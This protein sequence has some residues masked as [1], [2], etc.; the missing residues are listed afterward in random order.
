V[1]FSEDGDD[2]KKSYCKNCLSYGFKVPLKN[3]I[4]P[5]NEPIPIDDDQF[6]QCYECGL[7]VPVYENEKESSIKDVV[8]TA[9]NPFDIGKS[10][11]GIDSRTS[12]GGKNARKKRDRQK[13]LE[14]IKDENLKAELAKGNTSI[15]YIEYQPH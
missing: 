5:N 15:S 9:E 4:Y 7:I 2:S 3:R 8:E 10:F 12:V 14:D 6:L 1:D 11:L 13:A